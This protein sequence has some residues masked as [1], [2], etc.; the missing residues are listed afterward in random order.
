[1]RLR[2]SLLWFFLVMIL[3]L[4][5]LTT[6]IVARA[7]TNTSVPLKV[8]FLF[9]GPISDWGWSYAQN[10]GR[11]F[12][13]STLG[14]KVQTIF[15]ENIPENSEAERIMEKMIAQGAK[16]IFATSYAYLEPLLRVAARHPDVKFMQQ[17]RFETRSNV[18]T[19]FNF[20]YQ[21]MYI[22]GTVAGQMTKTSKVGFIAARPC[23]PLLQAIN[24]FALGVHAV[25]P[26]AQV[27]LVWTNNWI[28]P[29]TEAEAARGLIDTG[30]D[31]LG[32]DQSSPLTIVKTAESRGVYVG[33]CYTDVHQFAPKYWLT[34]AQF[35]WGPFYVKTI[36]SILN[37]TWKSSINIYDLSS[38]NVK[39]SPFGPAVPKK[40]QQAALALRDKIQQHQFIVF[41]GPITDT[42]GKQRLA[43]GKAPDAK[44]LANMDFLVAGVQGSIPTK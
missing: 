11:L 34:G 5:S 41:Q 44:W 8:G 25:N 19:F 40:I 1:M 21:V 37:N 28:D 31:V 20:H 23:P 16:V 30:V 13:E 18:G 32:F 27:K 36:Q 9:V 33:A 12:V 7:Q 15:A 29:P 10:Q 22:F 43:P 39:L 24:S 38:G 4:G 2:Q 6:V 26:K 17:S 42:F 14:N 3:C 35:V